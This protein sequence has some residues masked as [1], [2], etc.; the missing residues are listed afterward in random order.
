ML[1]GLRQSL[2][3]ELEKKSVFVS[4]TFLDLRDHRQ[5]VLDVILRLGMQPLAMEFFGADPSE[6]KDLLRREV[7]ACDIFIG[8]YAHRYGYIPPAGTAR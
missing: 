8:I 6:P 5:L 3:G 7:E 1:V 2:A 4:S